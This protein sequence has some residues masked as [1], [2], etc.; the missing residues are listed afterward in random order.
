MALVSA[1]YKFIAVDIGSYGKNSDGGIF[2]RSAL[3]RGL[4]NYSLNVPEA[5]ILPG[6]QEP[7]PYVIVGDE[8]FP[9]KPYLLRPYPA[10]TLHQ[11]HNDRKK[12]FNYRLSRARRVSENAFGIL[13]QKF[14]IY[15]RWLR[16]KPENVKIVVLTTCC[17]HN[18]CKSE[19]FNISTDAPKPTGLRHIPHTGGNFGQS[20]LN[21]R[22][23]FATY[24]NSDDGAVPWQI[25]VV[26]AGRQGDEH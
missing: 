17:L 10:S 1:D 7:V 4:E 18:F 25:D 6:M 23:L 21:I 22:E 24:F 13:S 2:S 26:S 16:L 5:R 12:V 9:L 19:T 20:T 11:D 8:V 14:G 15:Q 3:G